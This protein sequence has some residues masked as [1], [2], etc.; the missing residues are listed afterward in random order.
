MPTKRSIVLALPLVFA[1]G[2][3]VALSVLAL[4]ALILGLVLGV[5]ISPTAQD[6]GKV[7]AI[8]T[9]TSALSPGD[10]VLRAPIDAPD[11]LHEAQIARVSLEPDAVWIARHSNSG[12]SLEFPV[13]GDSFLRPIVKLPGWMSGS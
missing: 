11:E 12:E 6:Q 3:A 7:L 10:W 13:R 1:T 9:A 5:Q 4:G 8:P 2:A